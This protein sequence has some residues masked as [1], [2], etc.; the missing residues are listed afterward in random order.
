M[1]LDLEI[2]PAAPLRTTEP[3]FL[4]SPSV[5][6][7]YDGGLAS[8][9][10]LQAACEDMPKTRIVAVYVEMVPLVPNAVAARQQDAFAGKAILA[11]AMVNAATYGSRIETLCLET[12]TRGEALAQLAADCGDSTIYLGVDSAHPDWLADYLQAHAPAN[13]VLVQV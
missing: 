3:S 1:K 11:A 6:V 12:H 2:R 13:L 5:L 10:A 8:M 7:Y 9:A 4:P